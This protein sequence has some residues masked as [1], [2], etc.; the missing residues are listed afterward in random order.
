V[1]CRSATADE[2]SEMRLSAQASD[3]LA[4]AKEH[5]YDVVEVISKM[6]FHKTK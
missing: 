1:Y 6:G 2:D 3:C 5:C 4:Y